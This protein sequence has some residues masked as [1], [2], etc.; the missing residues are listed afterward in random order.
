MK[1]TKTGNIPV[2]YRKIPVFHFGE[3]ERTIDI[4]RGKKFTG[5]TTLSKSI[6]R[7]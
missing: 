5:Y 7:T 6:A 1:K 2:K 4:L 3:F